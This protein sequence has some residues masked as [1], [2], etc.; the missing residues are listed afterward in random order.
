MRINH[1][2]QAGR[3]WPG[4]AAAALVI[5]CSA[6]AGAAEPRA[7]KASNIE[8]VVGSAAGATPDV[9]MRRVAKVLN[10]EKIVTQP[11]VVQNR[12]G[13]G[14]TV[15]SNYVIGRPGSEG[16]L[17][18]IVPSVFT[19][20]IVQGGPNFYEKITPIAMFIRMD[21]VVMARPDS[22][23]KT[24]ADLVDAAKKKERSVQFA[25]ANVGSTDHI[26]TALIEKAGGV[27][28]NYV[29]FDGGGGIMGAFL[30]GS[31]DAIVLTPDEAYP[32][33]KGGK[34][35]PLAI[36]SEQRNGAPEYKDVPTAKEQ[37]LDIVWGSYYGISG[38][39]DL[40]P[41][42]VAWW[43]DKLAKMVQTDGWKEMIKE[44]FLS[45]EYV[46]SAKAK[47]MLDEIYQRFLG[48]LRD[49]QLAKK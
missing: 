1:I 40:D 28:I 41:A 37:G 46:G 33:I 4:L 7:P 36:L 45:S 47:P 39:P 48:V 5:G 21:L 27:K 19:T 12:T 34:A 17:F 14:W 29:P 30:G 2:K 43:D 11:I 13:G 23:Y 20:P 49:V 25:G 44:N 22:P 6:G 10:E 24:L 38:P 8:I 15:A 18:A 3:R 26:V 42:V 16:L 9:F 35:K 31:V 32:L